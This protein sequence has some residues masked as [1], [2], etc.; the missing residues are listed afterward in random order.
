M[1]KT[2][3][4]ARTHA[5]QDA[6]NHELVNTNPAPSIPHSSIRAHLLRREVVGLAVHAE[7]E[8][9]G[10]RPEKHGVSVPLVHVAVDDQ[11]LPDGLRVV[12]EGHVRCYLP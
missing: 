10:P 9:R 7:R 5:L 11:Y 3:T 6:G 4:K 1:G 12:P 2:Q 8:H